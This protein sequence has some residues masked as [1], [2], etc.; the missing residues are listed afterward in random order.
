M[1][2]RCAIPAAVLA[3]TVALVWLGFRG[4]TTAWGFPLLGVDARVFLPQ[5]LAFAE[6]GE[7]VNRVWQPAAALDVEGSGRMVYHGYLYPMVIAGLLGEGRS[8]KLSIVLSIIQTLAAL[9]L[10]LLLLDLGRRRGMRMNPAAWLWALAF[11]VATAVYSYGS[12][13]RPEPLVTLLMMVAV[14]IGWRLAP[15]WRVRGAG[16]LLG[17]VASLHPLVGVLAALATLA[18]CAWTLAPR[19]FLQSAVVAGGYA[20]ACF[21]LLMALVYPYRW[22]DWVLGTL[23]MGKVAMQDGRT[24]EALGHWMTN[25]PNWMLPVALLAIG[26]GGGWLVRGHWP[27]SPVAFGVVLIVAL[28]AVVRFTIIQHWATYNL[29]P[30]VP[31]GM[32]APYLA[33]TSRRSPLALRAGIAVCLLVVS[34]GVLRDLALRGMWLIDGVSLREAKRQLADFS[35]HH[36][37]A[38][39]AF[40]EPLFTLAPDSP[41]VDFYRESPPPTA[42]F[43]VVPQAFQLRATPPVIPG[44]TLLEDHFQASAPVV[45]GVALA[46]DQKGCGFAIYRRNQPP[47]TPR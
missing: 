5:A 33:V 29:V 40:A 21:T 15:A 20:M 47:E 30:F 41:Q 16:V 2:G 3:T 28:A 12:P 44:F 39:I 38:R 6:S 17:V 37:H 1:L 32:L 31:I 45:M 34:L 7:L 4:V 35:A 24:S 11:G 46:S 18:T 9:A 25:G 10:P 14:G 22:D 19:R 13:G 27:K 23:R 42:E 43:A 8:E 36:P 26:A